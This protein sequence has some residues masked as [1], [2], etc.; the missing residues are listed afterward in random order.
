MR[1][2]VKCNSMYI[3]GE[4]NCIYAKG[5]RSCM[6]LEGE[7]NCIYTWWERNCMCIEGQRNCTYIEGERD[8]I[9]HSERGIVCIQ[10]VQSLA[11]SQ[12]VHIYICIYVRILSWLLQYVYEVASSSRLLKITGLFCKRALLKRR[13]SAKDT[14]DFKEP[15]NRSHPIC[16]P[17]VFKKLKGKTFT[18]HNKQMQMTVE[19]RELS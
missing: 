2:H 4:R 10:G 8:C 3:E 14:Y 18:V 9:L 15:T 7:S 11:F 19:V 5:E 13:Y 12:S 17:Q 6:Y 1:W 16:V